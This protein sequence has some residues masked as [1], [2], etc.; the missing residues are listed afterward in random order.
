V[1]YQHI[2]VPVDGSEISLAAVQHAIQLAKMHQSKLSFISL[3]SENPFHDADFYSVGSS[4]MKEYFIQAQANAEAALTL[5]KDAAATAGVSTNSQIIQAEVSAK[6][7]IQFAENT[8]VDLIVVG[9][10][11]RK[12]FQKMMLGSFAQEV[13]ASTQLPVL[14][15]KQPLSTSQ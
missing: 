15:I 13:L 5:A 11:G 4:I 3:I 1:V 14:V 10:H 7:V 8:Q 2:L 6:Q 9:S 12:G